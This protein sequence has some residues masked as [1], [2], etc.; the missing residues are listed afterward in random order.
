MVINRLRAALGNNPTLNVYVQN[1]DSRGAGGT[2]G[3]YTYTL[4]GTDVE[5]LYPAAQELERALKDV[6]SVRD[7]GTDLQ[8]MNPTILLQIDRDKAGMLDITLRQIENALYSAFGTRQI[9]TI[10]TDVSDYTVKL[11]VLPELQIPHPSFPPYICA[12]EKVHWCLWTPSSPIKMKP[13]R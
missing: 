2:G 1:A 7:V 6:A 8:L 11:E 13:A 3:Q 5:E 10:Y 12:P 9:S 4:V